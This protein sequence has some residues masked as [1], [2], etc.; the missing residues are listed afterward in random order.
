MASNNNNTKRKK[1]PWFA[2]YVDDFVSG[3]IAM[4]MAARG[5]FVSMLAYQ[6]SN[7]TVP[8][9]DRSICRIIGAFPDEWE[10][11]K[12]EVLPKFRDNLDGTIANERMEKERLE[13]EGI[14]QSKIDAA[15]KRWS[16]KDADGDARAYAD[17][18]AGEHADAYADGY[19]DGGCLHDASTSTST[20]TSLEDKSSNNTHATKVAKRDLR[21]TASELIASIP[22]DFEPAKRE[23]AERFAKARQSYIPASKRFGTTGAFVMQCNRMK[24]YPADVLVDAVDSAIAGEWMSWEQESIKSKQIG[25]SYVD[26]AFSEGRF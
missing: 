9:D 15:K 20:S 2:F 8:S 3:T 10:A 22:E 26:N 11:I 25:K 1:S 18:Y 12:D 4:S 14:R 24:L 6:F 19:A 7:G 17:G 16:K 21:P 23:A 13:R 5:A